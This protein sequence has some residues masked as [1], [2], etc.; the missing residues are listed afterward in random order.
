[1]RFRKLEDV[2]AEFARQQKMQQENTKEKPVQTRSERTGL[3]FFDTVE[4]AKEAASK[5]QSIWKISY[6]DDKG[7]RVR[8]VRDGNDWK[9]E[10]IITEEQ[11]KTLFSHYR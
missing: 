9:P 11:A 3:K 7:Q 1:M 2:Q 6:N 5:D 10:P 8:L 4:L